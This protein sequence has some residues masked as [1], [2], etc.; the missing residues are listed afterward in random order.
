MKKMM[1]MKFPMMNPDYDNADNDDDD[2]D[3]NTDDQDDDNNAD[4]LA[5]EYYELEDATKGPPTELLRYVE[6]CHAT[7]STTPELH[8][9]LDSILQTTIQQTL[10]AGK[11]YTSDWDNQ[12]LIQVT[13]TTNETAPQHEAPPTLTRPCPHIVNDTSGVDN[14]MD[15]TNALPADI[16]PNTNPWDIVETNANLVPDPAADIISHPKPTTVAAALPLLPSNGTKPAAYLFKLPSYGTEHVLDTHALITLDTG[17][18][19]HKPI[20]TPSH[21]TMELEPGTSPPSRTR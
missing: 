9:D 20:R 2:D 15:K 6:R 8:S 11:L 21:D 4:L 19:W 14:N 10:V 7:C 1:L 12:P 16:N 17:G 13:S 5:L 3:D 18:A